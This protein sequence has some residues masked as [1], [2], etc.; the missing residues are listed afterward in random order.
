MI[1]AAERKI[2]VLGAT[3]FP[4]VVK[5]YA[6]DRVP[7]NLN[8]A[9]F[10]VVVLDLTPFEDNEQLRA[11]VQLG[12]LPTT[13]RFARLIFSGAEI[14]CIGSL[15]TT[16]ARTRA[17]ADGSVH[18][19]GETRVDWWLPVVLDVVEESAEIR[20]VDPLWSEYFELVKRSSW[21]F[22]HLDDGIIRNAR[23]SLSGI[24]VEADSVRVQ[25][26]VLASTRFGKAVGAELKVTGMWTGEDYPVEV[27]A[28]GCVVLLPR[29][30][31]VAVEEA[32]AF[33]LR[34]RYLVAAERRK[35]EWIGDFALPAETGP[36][37]LV[38]LQRAAIDEATRSLKVAEER[39]RDEA[40]FRK[41]LYETG[42]DVLEPIVRDALRALGA[43]VADP[44]DKGHEDGRMTWPPDHRG[45]LEIKGRRTGLK[46]RDV[47]ELDQW[48]RDAL[49]DW[50]SK[51]VLIACLENEKRPGDRSRL[52]P[53][54]CVAFA[55][56]AEICLLTTTQLFEALRR[57]QLRELDVGVFFETLFR[58]SGV[59]SLPEV[60][61]P[62]ADTGR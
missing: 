13:D 58:T 54:N 12:R 41:L 38:R 43:E 60:A 50:T 52:F 7:E 29:P 4:L 45:M 32:I 19:V 5:A 31:E 47:R 28:E 15:T 37:E 40:R 17:W 56:R 22:D 36:R 27:T 48:V 39:V 30:T 10:D 1:D 6:W 23:Y 25:S 2:L 14:V 11:G 34:E 24:S 21:Y 33:V 20:D 3:G 18:R 35:P 42:E 53:A 44:E 59:C 8:V 9:D 55:E 46:L 57:H 26:N 49:V 62:G 51:G 61:D 16:L